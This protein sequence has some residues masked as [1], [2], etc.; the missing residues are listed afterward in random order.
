MKIDSTLKF[1][2]VASVVLVLSGGTGE[3]MMGMPLWKFLL[4][5]GFIAWV[6]YNVPNIFRQF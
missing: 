3:T 4:T 6:A 5:A 2:I 1:M